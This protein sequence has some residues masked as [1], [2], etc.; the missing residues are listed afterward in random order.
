MDWDDRS[1]GPNA[2][3]LQALWVDFVLHWLGG[4]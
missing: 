4:A 2:K 3:G 1:R